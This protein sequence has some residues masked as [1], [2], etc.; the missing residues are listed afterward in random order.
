VWGYC[1]QHKDGGKDISKHERGTHYG[2]TT[3]HKVDKG[4][5]G[6]RDSGRNYIGPVDLTDDMLRADC[7]FTTS[8]KMANNLSICWDCLRCV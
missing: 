4:G 5:S 2:D 6:D 1:R 8:G 7:V 3:I